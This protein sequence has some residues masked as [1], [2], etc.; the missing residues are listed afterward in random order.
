[1]LQARLPSLT[2]M[3]RR[4]SPTDFP[5][6]PASGPRVWREWGD[7]GMPPR[8]GDKFSVGFRPHCGS[9]RVQNG[10]PKATAM[11]D[12]VIGSIP[13]RGTTL[14][15][16]SFPPPTDLADA[17]EHFW[18]VENPRALDAHQEILIPNGRPTVLICLGEPGTRI[19]MDGTRLE[20]ASNA[21]GII[22]S[23]IILEQ[24]G[25]SSYVAA[26]LR[27]WGLALF[28]FPALVNQSASLE[29]TIGGESL[30]ILITQCSS[31][32]FGEQR[33]APL[34]ELLR[35][36]RKPHQQSH[37]DQI[38]TAT[39]AIDRD[40]DLVTV[41][42]LAAGMQLSYERLY[43][44][45]KAMLGVSPKQYASIMRFYNFTSGL[46]KD[47]HGS[48]AQLASLQ[49]YY[50]QSHAAREFKRYTGISQR[51]FRQTLNGI[52]KLM[53]VRSH[54]QDSYKN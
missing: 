21:A 37:L 46:L 36:L 5:P 1:M 16:Q 44:L 23:P 53:Q 38:L 17:V 2:P 29:N 40:A 27:P 52:A 48:T 28:G 15:Y 11:A 25:T 39:E 10:L 45:F 9:W 3:E 30:D 24:S 51:Q 33:T 20:N 35:G 19:W 41:E 42:R 7:D 31:E 18:A 32:P 12:V 43:R 4:P 22:T 34:I 49:G 8:Q 50:D 54:L 26:Q 13:S 14:Q 6:G 47:G